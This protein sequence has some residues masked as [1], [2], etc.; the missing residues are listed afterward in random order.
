MDKALDS[1]RRAVALDG[2]LAPAWY[3]IALIHA[4]ARNRDKA[5]D[6][7]EKAVTYGGEKYAQRARSAT[8]FE[9]LHRDTRFF[10]IL[11]STPR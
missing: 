5:L 3:E 7:L 10:E 11:R 1:L 9:W 4:H 8:Q 6:N 2:A